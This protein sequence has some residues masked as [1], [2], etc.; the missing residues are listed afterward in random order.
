MPKKITLAQ[1]HLGGNEPAALGGA[2]AAAEVHVRRKLY[3]LNQHHSSAG[4]SGA[5]RDPIPENA[6][7]PTPKYEPSP[8]L[9]APAAGMGVGFGAGVNSATGAGAGGVGALLGYSATGHGFVEEPT[10][11]LTWILLLIMTFVLLFSCS[12]S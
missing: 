8:N 2:K 12:C 11:E 9:G 4:V 5:F 3:G 7:A 6:D 1:N 10:S